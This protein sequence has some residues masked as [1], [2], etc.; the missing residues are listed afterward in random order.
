LKENKEKEKE[1]ILTKK[2]KSMKVTST[3]IKKMG[4]ESK[5][6]QMEIYTLENSKIIKNMEM[7]DSSGLVSPPKIPNKMSM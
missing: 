6:I 1:S 3:E 5:Y 4:S 7:E 2:E